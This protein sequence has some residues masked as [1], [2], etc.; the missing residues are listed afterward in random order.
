MPYFL[1]SGIAKLGP[2]RT[3]VLVLAYLAVAKN[4][5]GIMRLKGSNYVTAKATNIL[6][7]V[8]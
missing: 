4:L 6:I 5:M 1:C 7:I 2:I 8:V 3:L